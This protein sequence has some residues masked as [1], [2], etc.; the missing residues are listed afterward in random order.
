MDHKSSVPA[1]RIISPNYAQSGLPPIAAFITISGNL[2]RTFMGATVP[3]TRS[4]RIVFYREA[5][6]SC[7]SRPDKLPRATAL[8]NTHGG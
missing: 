5:Q 3:S 4:W 8:S 6:P 2:S 1:K 7:S